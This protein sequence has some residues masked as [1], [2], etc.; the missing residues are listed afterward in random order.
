MQVPHVVRIIEEENLKRHAEWLAIC[1]LDEF[2]YGVQTKFST[3]LRLHFT[4]YDVV[5]VPWRMFGTSGMIEQPEDVRLNNTLRKPD[6][7]TTTKFVIRPANVDIS[8][9][10]LHLVQYPTNIVS[11]RPMILSCE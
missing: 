4:D 3:T 7:D 2:F 10:S 6:I 9:I 8:K 1:D 11:R 5:Y